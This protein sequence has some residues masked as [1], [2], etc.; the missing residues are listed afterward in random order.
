[1]N[2]ETTASQP[3]NLAQQRHT[4]PDA[5]CGLIGARMC[6]G[7]FDA[8]AAHR[9][10]IG[11]EKSVGDLLPAKCDALMVEINLHK[12]AFADQHSHPTRFRAAF[13]LVAPMADVIAS[14]YCENNACVSIPAQCQPTCR[15]FGPRSRRT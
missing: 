2:E 10:L 13:E 11:F 8:A 7:E 9:S 4:V 6:A 5:F 15:G 3:D 1:M 12:I 14:L